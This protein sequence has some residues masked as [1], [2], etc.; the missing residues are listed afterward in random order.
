MRL[1]AIT[2]LI[3]ISLT[4][5]AKLS[6]EE[7]RYPSPIH[8]ETK[9][10]RIHFQGGPRGLDGKSNSFYQIIQ[11]SPN[12]LGDSL[13]MESAHTIAGFGYEEQYDRKDWIRIVEDPHGPASAN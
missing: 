10:F 7:T 11:K 4:S 3:V 1:L 13:V 6:R 12:G 8:W 2:S 9:N 5:C